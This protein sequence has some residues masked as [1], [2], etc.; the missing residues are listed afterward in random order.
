MAVAALTGCGGD[1]SSSSSSKA[2]QDTTKTVNNTLKA[3]FTASSLYTDLFNK[4]KTQTDKT[5]L[6]I[7][8]YSIHGIRVD[9]G[10][11]KVISDEDG[12]FTCSS[13]PLNFY[14]GNFKVGTISKVPK[15][16][17]I[18]TQ[19]I[20]NVPRAATTHPDVTK[21]SMI[22]QSLDEDADLSNGIELTQKSIDLLDNELANFS[23]I[24]QLTLN[25]TYQIIERIIVARKANNADIKLKK[26]SQ[27]EAQIN[28]TKALSNTPGS[29]IDM[30]TLNSIAL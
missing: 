26:V 19:D 16:K 8:A 12:F 3:A 4:L 17:I 20:L 28:L 14:L 24:H 18:Y 5:G 2:P 1:S 22:L 7:D 23:S 21:L 27:K 6:L 9:C 30:S 13:T 15:D 29:N 10:V 25:D 11:Q